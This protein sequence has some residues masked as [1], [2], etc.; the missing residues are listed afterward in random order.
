MDQGHATAQGAAGKWTVCDRDV[1]LLIVEES[2]PEV[3]ETDWET[4]SGRRKIPWG[5]SDAGAELRGSAVIRS[6][7]TTVNAQNPRLHIS[8]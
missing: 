3:P 4:S 1:S 8:P 5:Q 6:T 7:A 2:V